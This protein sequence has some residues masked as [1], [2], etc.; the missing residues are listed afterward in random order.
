MHSNNRSEQL[1]N[2]A[3][4]PNSECNKCKKFVSD[5]S[6]GQTNLDEFSAYYFL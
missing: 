3:M 5:K 6:F 2:G 1:M 4:S